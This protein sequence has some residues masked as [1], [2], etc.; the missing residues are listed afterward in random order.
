MRCR[1]EICDNFVS[2]RRFGLSAPGQKNCLAA[3][4]GRAEPVQTRG[5]VGSRRPRTELDRASAALA[6]DVR[7]PD[8]SGVRV[9]RF[10]ARSVNPL[11]SRCHISTQAPRQD[12]DTPAELEFRSYAHRLGLRFRVDATPLP[13]LRRRADVVF[14]RQQV[15]VFLDGCFWH[16]CP[17]HGSWPTANGTWWRLKIQRNRARDAETDQLLSEAGWLVLRFWEHDDLEAA[18]AKVAAAVRKRG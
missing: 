16:G 13:S 8:G 7:A 6:S 18:A 1:R 12:S 4:P 3:C 15:A 2:R 14:P 17:H 5:E 11:A 10:I 9:G